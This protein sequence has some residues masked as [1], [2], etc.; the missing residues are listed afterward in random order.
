M[1]YCNIKDKTLGKKLDKVFFTGNRNKIANLIDT[2]S[3]KEWFG[4]GMLDSDGN[5][6]MN[7]EF[8]FTNEKGQKKTVFDFEDI[9]FTSRQEVINAIKSIPSIQAHKGKLYLNNTKRAQDGSFLAKIGDNAIKLVNH[10]HPDLLSIKRTKRLGD[11]DFS[12]S[13]S[14]PL[15]EIEVGDLQKSPKPIFSYHEI[16]KDERF[17]QVP[18]IDDLITLHDASEKYDLLFNPNQT[19]DKVITEDTYKLLEEFLLAINPDFKIEKLDDLSQNGISYIRNFLIELKT[20]KE[21]Q[22]MPEEVAHFFVELLPKSSELRTSLLDNIINFKIYGDTF[23]KYKNLED[24]QI[25]GKVNIDK[26]KREAAAKLIG[27]YIYAITTKDDS[28]IQELTKV[29][30][31]FIKR[32][33]DELID[34]IYSKFSKIRNKKTQAFIDAANAI[35]NKDVSLLSTKEII[36]NADNLEFFQLSYGDIPRI[37]S[38]IVDKVTEANKLD[39]LKN[40]ISDFERSLRTKFLPAV[41]KS[42]FSFVDA[43]T[44]EDNV[45]NILLKISDVKKSITSVVNAGA[46]I[47]YVENLSSFISS[48]QDFKKVANQ[49]IALTNEKLPDEQTKTILEKVK[50]LALFRNA[51]LNLSSL[52]SDDFRNILAES[53]TGLEIINEITE[54]VGTFES[55]D[56]IMKAKLIDVTKKFWNNWIKTIA[57]PEIERINKEIAILRSR[58]YVNERAVKELEQQKAQLMTSDAIAEEII[59]GVGPDMDIHSQLGHYI[60]PSI[61]NGDMWYASIAKYVIA[62][63]VA[64]EGRAISENIELASKYHELLK[65]TGLDVYQAG[66]KMTYI[67]TVKDITVKGGTRQVVRFVNPHINEINLLRDKMTDELRDINRQLEDKSIS[68]YKELEEK[69]NQLLKNYN[70]FY[71]NYYNSPYSDEFIKFKQKWDSNEKFL[72]IKQDYD[73]YSKNIAQEM[74]IVLT[75]DSLLEKNLAKYRMIEERAKR[76]ALFKIKNEN[77]ELSES[78]SLLKQY[79][80]ESSKFRETDTRAVERNVKI[81][82]NHFSNKADIAISKVL[83]KVKSS[84]NSSYDTLWDEIEGILR[85]ELKMFNL[86]IRY[87][88]ASAANSETTSLKPINNKIVGNENDAEVLKDVLLQEFS[89]TIYVEVKTEKF[90]EDK[91]RIME[92]LKLLKDKDRTFTENGKEYSFDFVDKK[93]GE[94]YEKIFDILTD[95][96][97]DYGQRNPENLSVEELET[98]SNLEDFITENLND[99]KVQIYDLDDTNISSRPDLKEIIKNYQKL[100]KNYIVELTDSFEKGTRNNKFLQSAKES[101]IEFNS[102]LKD[103]NILTDEQL[104][105]KEYI[106]ELYRELSNLQEKSPTE[107]YWEYMDNML[108]FFNDYIKTFP[109]KDK[110]D[111][112]LRESLN[113]N[114]ENLQNA[115]IGR[116]YNTLYKFFNGEFIYDSPIIKS[117]PDLFG[118][119]LEFLDSSDNESHNEFADWFKESHIQGYLYEKYLDEY[120]EERTARI[121]TRYIPRLVY[122]YTDVARDEDTNP[123]NPSH[124]KREVVKR[125]RVSKIKDSETREKIKYDTINPATGELYDIEDWNYSDK[126]G[127]LPLSKKQLSEKHGSK[128]SNYEQYL[129]KDFYELAKDKNLLNLLMFSI[130]YYFDKESD[131]PKEIRGG[132]NIPVTRLDSFQSKE[133]AIKNA[134]GTLR[135]FGSH[136]KQ[137]LGKDNTESKALDEEEGITTQKDYDTATGKVMQNYRDSIPQLGMNGKL[138]VDEVNTNIL[139][140]LTIYNFKSE[141]YK[142][143]MDLDPI[144]KTITSIGGLNSS[145]SKR[146]KAIEE[147]RS[148]QVLLEVPDNFFNNPTIKKIM[149]GFMG[150]SAMKLM[151]DLIGGTTNYIQAS[152]NNMI[153]SFAGKHLSKLDYAQGNKLATMMMRD[154]IADF[155]S[156]DDFNYYTLLYQAYD[157]VPGDAKEDIIGR[158]SVKAKIF[159]FTSWLMLPRKGGELHAQSAMALGI[160]NGIKVRNQLDGKDY[161][162]HQIYEK[163]DKKL[164][165]KEGFYEIETQ[166]DPAGNDVEVKV[167]PWNIEDGK[168]YLALK[169]K[170]MNVSIELQGNYAKFTSTQISRHSVGNI[171]ELMK[172]FIPVSFQRRWGRARLDMGTETLEQGYYLTSVK[173]V[174]NMLFPLMKGN[175][176]QFQSEADFIFNVSKKEKIAMLRTI[177][178]LVAALILFL[179][180]TFV[181]GYDDDD[182]ERFKRLRGESHFYN[183]SLLVLLKAYQEQTSFIP[184]PGF[185]YQELKRTITDPLSLFRDSVSN[186]AGVADLGFKHLLYELGADGFQK[187]LFYQKDS[188]MFSEKGDSKMIKYLLKNLGWTGATFDTVEYIKNFENMQSRIK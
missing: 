126:D 101:I 93:I 35:L 132:Y 179:L 89:K 86:N 95:R 175:F 107:T 6:V 70:E 177:A 63:R 105:E 150:I 96:N 11:K 83:N 31:S 116:D 92:Q 131:K 129:N 78:S 167:Y 53:N 138:N 3:F 2:P 182:E 186:A 39:D 30:S 98:L 15:Y 130:R 81:E 7:N 4:K 115:I 173:A 85:D 149:N 181:M 61:K 151:G 14:I 125:L 164:V 161:P 152:I 145:S 44:K 120:D 142:A 128:A 48:L 97:D 171:V 9:V 155:S 59:K 88:Y 176:K 72:Q 57:E 37:A 38:V 159:D 71:A 16:K 158:T 77:G 66:K 74:D 187:D 69:R 163:K 49:L 184:L 46:A 141:D 102:I 64:A 75:S 58:T 82:T 24:Y 76:S 154:I 111:R 22:A 134:P 127:W 157:F 108:Y 146:M 156:V 168:N 50:Y 68:N 62:E 153:E 114:F 162:V 113:Q 13:V 5:P 17:Y 140:A 51:Y 80:E 188:G 29:K 65:K 42:G 180:A 143:R 170:I 148:Q 20:G 106:Q 87:K 122:S 36:E 45:A 43:E 27:E 91:K 165:L 185:G 103:A 28:K 147:L 56:T 84:S 117:K 135:V 104:G 136:I 12:K 54:I 40:V 1:A 169:L 73:N 34:W 47:S 166:K 25:N 8:S 110:K 60:L 52:I 123:I 133:K 18:N 109:A 21:L 137:A 174:W 23:E 41:N 118:G 144:L 79:F 90:Y 10:Y 99:L 26:I 178:D 55:L 160:M 100:V 172:K 67:D 121:E 183:L 19:P 124:I 32:W 112:I 94:V 119:F 139:H 33:W